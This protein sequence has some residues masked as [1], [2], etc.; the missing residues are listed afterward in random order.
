MAKY[1]VKPKPYKELGDTAKFYRNA[2]PAQKAKHLASSAK[3]N[4]KEGAGKRRT[5]STN[6]RDSLKIKDPH[7]NA[8]HTKNGGFKAVSDKKNKGYNGS[9]KRS[10]YHA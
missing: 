3:A 2:T 9:G 10:R 4:R 5:A 6:A 1:G 7:V 8:G